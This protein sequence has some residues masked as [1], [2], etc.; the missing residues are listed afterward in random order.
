MTRALTAAAIKGDRKSHPAERPREGTKLRA[1][2]DALRR[3]ERLRQTPGRNFTRL[4]DEYQME[5]GS[6]R[7]PRGG[8]WLVGEWEGEDFVP[9]ERILQ[10][11]MAA[12]APRAKAA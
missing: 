6:A 7:G 5:L 4:R 8:V 1:L 9:L 11:D 10:E 2:Y 3:G 12:P